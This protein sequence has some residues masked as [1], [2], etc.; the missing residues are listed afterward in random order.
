[1]KLSDLQKA[2]DY[3]TLAPNFGVS[4]AVLKSHLYGGSGYTVFPIAK[5]SG[6]VRVISSPVKLRRSL[7]KKLL[8]V[9]AGAYR[10][11]NFSHGFVSE[12]NVR[13]NALPH[14]GKRTLINVDLQEFFSTIT[15]KRIRGLFLK[16][17]FSLHWSV[18]NI[19]S[20]ICCCNG[21]LPAGGIT[22]PV[23][24]NLLMSRLDKRMASL[25]TRL[26]GDYSRYADDLTM[27]FNR[28]LDQLSSLVL[29]DD[30]GAISIGGA[31]SEIIT[32]EGFIVNQEK[33]RISAFGSRKIVTGLVVNRKVNVSKKW[34]SSL[35]SKIYAVERFG[36][37]E[38]AQ[39]EY[40]EEENPGVA[41]RMLIRRIHGKLSFL[42]MVRG[43]GDWIFAD[44]AYRFNKV[45][46]GGE[47]R[48]SSVEF[49]SRKERVPRG[50][51]VVVCSPSA[52]SAYAMADSQG[53]GFCVSS[54]LIVT[55][56]HVIAES[57]GKTFSNVYVM[58]ERNKVLE[59]CDVLAF[60]EHRDIAILKLKSSCADLERHRF[61]LKYSFDLGCNVISA[62]YPDY[63]IGN[64]A[65]VQQH[66][67]VKRFVSSLVCKAQI[68]GV[69]QGG[70]SGGP[71][72]D[73]EM[74]VIGLM[75]KGTLSP[76]GIPEMIEAQEIKKVA[77][78]AG[79][80][81]F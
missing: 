60:D 52:L 50:V 49:I 9:L 20:Q 75:H 66:Q 80:K 8:P 47:L 28:S 11:N 54:G 23:L 16:S 5:K 27:S 59:L 34:K 43:H 1:M 56:A 57:A 18:A 69:A 64:V 13:S 39:K 51:F 44:L 36:W 46:A 10:P 7:Q 70:L 72:I 12:K 33:I 35:E 26:G 2:Y 29:V 24:S 63:V 77:A 71:V 68:N 6:G 17:P 19:L 61:K 79:L 22:S 30:I 53:T 48:L 32:T 15:F 67:V 74:H 45:N 38:V 58:N 78:N 3:H 21:V 62:G 41:V 40:P 25:I 55:A 73:D 81:I 4:P 14:V 31:L 76:G 65:S 37:L 42:N